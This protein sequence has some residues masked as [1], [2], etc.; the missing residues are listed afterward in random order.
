MLTLVAH[1]Q[2]HCGVK[3]YFGFPVSFLEFGILQE[4]ADQG[5]GISYIF[6]RGKH[7]ISKSN[8]NNFP[9]LSFG[10]DFDC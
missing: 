10:F 1:P 6:G 9:G 8:S 4:Y 5:K 7:N 3:F 2:L